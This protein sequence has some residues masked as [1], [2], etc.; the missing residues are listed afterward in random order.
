VIVAAGDNSD[1]VA[2][3][4]SSLSPLRLSLLPVNVNLERPANARWAFSCALYP[5]C[6]RVAVA[7]PAAARG[8]IAMKKGQE[9]QAN[10]D[11]KHIT[12]DVPRVIAVTD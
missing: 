6:R 11:H 9:L 7:L 8:V 3:F 2:S 4:Q 1:D 12:C 5:S 10:R